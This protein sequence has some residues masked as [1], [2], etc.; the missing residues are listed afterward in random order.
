MADEQVTLQVNF[1]GIKSLKTEL[2]EANNEYQKLIN[3]GQ[4]TADQIDAAARKV[5][6]FKDQIKEANERAQALGSAE[7]KIKAIG[8]AAQVGVSA[9]QGVQAAMAL[10]GGESEALEKTMVKLQALMSLQQAIAGLEGAGDAFKNLGKI[11]M[12]AFGSIKT[13]IGSTGIGLLVVALGL[14]YANFEKIQDIATKLFPGISNLVSMFGNLITKA[15]DFVGIT[16]AGVRA[17]ENLDKA[18]KKGLDTGNKELELMKARGASAKEIYEYEKKL[19]QARITDLENVAKKGKGLSDEQQKEKEDIIQKNKILDAQETK[20][21]ADEQEKRNQK[22]IENKQKANAKAKELDD[23]RKEEINKLNSDIN[24]DQE[25]VQEERDKMSMSEKEKEEYDVKKHYDNLKKEAERLKQDTTKIE[26]LKNAQLALIDEKFAKKAKD[27]LIKKQEDEAKIIADNYAEIDKLSRTA[28]ENELAELAD[29]YEKLLATEGLSQEQRAMLEEQWAQKKKDVEVGHAKK[30]ADELKKIEEEKRKDTYDTINASI[31][32]FSDISNAAM[33]LSDQVTKNRLANVEKGS[34]EEERILK[35]QFE[36]QK[37]MQI[38][39]ALINGA[40]AVTAILSVPDF[41]LGIASGIRIAAAGV[42][43]GLTVAKIASTQFEGGGGGGES[44]GSKFANGGL[45]MGRKHAEGGVMTNFGEL[46]G[47]EYVV[48]RE[49]T[50][51]FLPMLE[52]IN[53]MGSGSGTPNNLS[54]N[55][56][57]SQSSQ[58]IIKTYVVASD[59]TS[60]Q[61]VQRK[62]NNLARL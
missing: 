58:P 37:A 11:G 41:T 54:T 40:Q 31:Q 36:T 5:G 52:K 55:A 17:A 8:D 19:G 27:D 48:N 24:S 22:A 20:R 35:K 43:T 18:S 47:G 34:A 10:T 51:S 14:V 44:K 59:V 46:E 1:E 33:A 49:A 30:A 21:L 62:I 7:G 23:K 38:A 9:F 16:D 12:K 45:L 4:A 56:E 50:A 61:E 57:T 39:M 3:S 13:A 6:D 2:K 53:S 15:T 29:Y 25:K 60:Q 32:A 26:E 42:T 28:E